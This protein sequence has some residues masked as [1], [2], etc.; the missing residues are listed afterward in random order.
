MMGMIMRL[1]NIILAV[2]S[3]PLVFHFSN[4]NAITKTSLRPRPT[5]STTPVPSATPI[6]TA[7]PV[8]TTT[9][10]PTA[11]PIATAPDGGTWVRI[12]LVLQSDHPFRNCTSDAITYPVTFKGAT[13][14][15]FVVPKTQFSG[16]AS[17]SIKRPNSYG[18]ETTVPGNIGVIDGAA[19]PTPSPT[20]AS[21]D[22]GDDYGST[23]GDDY[24]DDSGSTP[25]TQPTQ[26]YIIKGDSAIVS[27]Y[28]YEN[29][30]GKYGFLI[31]DI[32]VSLH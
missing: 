15:L 23:Y 26:T 11:T 3:L 9:P 27:W 7:T 6:L 1:V 10:V 25:D 4:A 5:P 32:Y 2:L 31:S 13:S 21:D 17:L 30:S 14:M 18:S 20:P 12:P 28:C 22:G 8:A 24:G 29:S 16:G 19:T